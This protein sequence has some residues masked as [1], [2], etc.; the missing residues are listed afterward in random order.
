ME[1]TGA[2]SSKRAERPARETVVAAS[3]HEYQ[4]AISYLYERINYEKTAD[5]APYPF[6]LRRM[7]EFL[8]R[9]DLHGIAGKSVPVIHVAG[10]KGKGST[11]TMVASML[12]AGGFRTGLYTSPHLM[13]LEERFTVNGT[14]PSESDVVL[15]IDSI[16]IEADQMARTNL[17][18][19]TFFEMTTAMALMHFRNSQC[20]A[21][22]LE[23]GLGGKLDST[24]VCYPAVTAIT[25]IGFDHQHILGNTLGEIAS[26]KAGIIKDG[27]PIVSGTVQTEARDVIQQIASRKNA[28]LFQINTDFSCE[29]KNAIS[30]DDWTTT[31]DLIS[32]QA[33]VRK[34]T[35]WTTSLDGDHQARNACVACAIVDLLALQGYKISDADQKA[36]LSKVPIAGRIERFRL[37]GNLDVILDTAHNTDS[38]DA[39]CDCVERRAQ[40]RPVTVVF[41]TSRD[42]EHKPMLARLCQ[43]A[44]ELILTRYFGNPRYRETSEL[45][46]DLPSGCSA[47]V[48]ENPQAAVETAIRRYANSQLV[49][50]CG[51]FFLAAEVRPL[52][53]KLIQP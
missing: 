40:G 19:P 31:F 20:N 3:S 53:E 5:S 16:A 48:I 37:P 27:V 42:K 30:P 22:V 14:M 18:V 49:V 34:R 2:E 7:S 41:G 24:N 21:V 43:V 39:L 11:A 45:K 50:I 10:T 1:P 6:R 44:D 9:F 33:P 25:S 8:D 47:S 4:R 52:L 13:R 38:I 46:R 51:S 29:L 35:D 17:G 23:V 28:P 36:G 26:Q 15:M 32:H 12:T